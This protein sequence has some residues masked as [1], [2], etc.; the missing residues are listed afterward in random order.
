MKNNVHKQI[1]GVCWIIFG[2]LIFSLLVLKFDSVSRLIAISGM[3]VS[4]VYLAAG[5]TLMANLRKASWIC[6]PCSVLS[7]LNFPLGTLV[8]IYYFWYYFR[9]ERAN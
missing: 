7:L 1:I 9:I 6:L 2:A 8:G 5:F 3:L 4:L